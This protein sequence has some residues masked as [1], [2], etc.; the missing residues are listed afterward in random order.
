MR[1]LDHNH[2]GTLQRAENTAVRRRDA[3]LRQPNPLPS[4]T[5]H[6]QLVIRYIRVIAGA[7]EATI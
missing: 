1:R 2:Y 3:T 6:L 7:S 4:T 5:F